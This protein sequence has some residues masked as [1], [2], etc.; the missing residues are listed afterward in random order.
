[1][2]GLDLAVQKMKKGEEALIVVDPSYCSP[3]NFPF[4]TL[5]NQK[6]YFKVELTDFKD[7]KKNR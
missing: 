6:S 5:V 7:K 3:D 1:M 4:A 2:K